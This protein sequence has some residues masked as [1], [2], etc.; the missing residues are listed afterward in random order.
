MDNPKKESSTIKEPFNNNDNNDD[1]NDNNDNKKSLFCKKN[2][3]YLLA[4]ILFV[5][6]IYYVIFYDSNSN[7]NTS[8]NETEISTLI[9]NTE[10]NEDPTLENLNQEFNN[11]HT[12]INKKQN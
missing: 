11:L 12:S 3:L 4:F 2:L 8:K 6:F 10:Y 5:G 7:S 1:N 9:T